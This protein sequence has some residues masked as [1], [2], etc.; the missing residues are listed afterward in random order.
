MSTLLMMT[1]TG[2]NRKWTAN[3]PKRKRAHEP[4]QILFCFTFFNFLSRR[5]VKSSLSQN[6]V[7]LD[8]HSHLAGS[9][10]L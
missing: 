6:D 4:S 1:F 2:P 7:T 3:H 5:T 10:Y 8:Y 9:V